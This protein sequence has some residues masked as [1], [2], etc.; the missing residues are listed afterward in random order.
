MKYIVLRLSAPLMSFGE[1]D[2]WDIRSTGV[3]TTKS[4]VSGLLAT[5]F[6]WSRNDVEQIRNLSDNISVSVRQDNHFSLLRDYHTIL[7]TLKADGKPNP[8]AVQSYRSY[9]MDGEFS[10]LISANSET[11][12][13]EIKTALDNPQWPVFLGRKSCVPS[14]P[15]YWDEII[16]AEN[17]HAAFQ[18]LP[19]LSSVRHK[20][21]N[22]QFEPLQDNQKQYACFTDEKTKN[23][24]VK[25]T[26]IRDNIVNSQLRVFSQ[27]EIYKFFVEVTANV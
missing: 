18:N 6:G 13:N 11:L 22:K 27:R 1:G 25:K 20:K 7:N 16:E 9:I 24:S 19:L 8:H 2:Y 17:S 14:L 26:L 15:I 12:F 23:I 3:F 5:C 21:F 4:A 10:V